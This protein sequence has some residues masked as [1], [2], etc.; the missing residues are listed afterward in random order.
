MGS[1]LGFLFLDEPR[2]RAARL[3]THNL[4][5]G[6]LPQT[7]RQPQ[8]EGRTER[9]RFGAALVVVRPAQ[10]GCTVGEVLSGRVEARRDHQAASNRRLPPELAPFLSLGPDPLEAEIQERG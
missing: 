10:A 2:V 6:W 1:G 8:A 3:G 7:N 4:T 5:S 9:S